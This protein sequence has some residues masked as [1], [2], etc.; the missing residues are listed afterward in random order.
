MRVLFTTFAWPSHF[1]GMVP[2]A[3]AFQS[4][5]HEVVV[6]SQPQLAETIA[7]AGLHA[8]VVGHD[9]DMRAMMHQPQYQQVGDTL[10][11][12]AVGTL[13]PEVLPEAE[14]AKWLT[15]LWHTCQV[16]E[17]MTD[18]L[19]DFVGDWRP[20]LI[21]RDPSTFGA[22][23]AAR[24]H[25]VP[26]ARVT[27]CP[28]VMG[29]AFD[30]RAALGSPD[31]AGFF[32]RHGLTVEDSWARWTVDQCPPAL[33]L[34]T[35]TERIPMRHVPYATGGTVPDWLLA[36]K[37][38]PRICLTWGF[39]T[40]LLRSEAIGVPQL[41]GALEGI[42]CEVVIPGGRGLPGMP[43]DLPGTVRVL[44]Y[45]PLTML[46]PTCDALLHHGGG[47]SMLMAAAQGVPQLMFPQIIDQAVYAH[48][49][50]RTGAGQVVDRSDTDPAALRRHV[51]RFLETGSY[52]EAALR[53][54][55]EIAAQPAPA[56]VVD[57]LRSLVDRT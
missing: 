16:A 43:A 23:V 37:S 30:A 38:R 39:T 3:W 54:Q 40:E 5:G 15:M 8:A 7:G 33:R 42:D 31:L 26:D 41:L 9:P 55:A 4:A 36:P 48:Q 51:R 19:V 52:R 24:K 56:A 45:L 25:G 13:P 17:T 35:A 29:K 6:A 10:L 14:K 27:L 47:G 22:S 57:T 21:V 20:D 12:E 18:D 28:D 46:L 50:A 32:E 11:D 53:L 34:P 1:Y 49:L 44:D 2:L